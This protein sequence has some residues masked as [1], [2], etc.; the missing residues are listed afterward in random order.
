MTPEHLGELIALGREIKW[1]LNDSEHAVHPTDPRL[2]GIY[3]TI[4]FDDLG[5]VERRRCTSAT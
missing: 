5:D 1:A 2:N 3:G 4:W